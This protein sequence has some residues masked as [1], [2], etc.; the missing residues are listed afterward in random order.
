MI[1]PNTTFRPNRIIDSRANISSKTHRTNGRDDNEKAD[2]IDR[3][4]AKL[5]ECPKLIWRH[6]SKSIQK[7]RS[8]GSHE[9]LK[10][11]G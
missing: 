7:S 9:T 6:I 4:C 10:M 8:N 3:A 11:K 2:L 5:I 1:T